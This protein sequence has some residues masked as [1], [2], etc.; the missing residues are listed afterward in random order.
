MGW[1]ADMERLQYLIYDELLILIITVDLG[2]NAVTDLLIL[3]LSMK[4]WFFW[5]TELFFVLYT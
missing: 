3:D 2:N 1:S 5:D 4:R